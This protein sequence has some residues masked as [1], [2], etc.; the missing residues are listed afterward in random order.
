MA[1]IYTYNI[2]FIKYFTKNC[3]HKR[4]GLYYLLSAFLFGLSVFSAYLFPRIFFL[5]IN[6]WLNRRKIRNRTTDIWMDCCLGAR[7][8]DIVPT[9][10]WLVWWIHVNIAASFGIFFIFITLKLSLF[11]WLQLYQV[12]HL[13]QIP[14]ICILFYKAFNQQTEHVFLLI[15]SQRLLE[16]FMLFR[17]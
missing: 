2:H 13:H 16:L 8:I 12:H 14:T 5:L 10:Y 11:L 3:N 15:A 1:K 17:I 4:I 9:W 7:V 6:Q